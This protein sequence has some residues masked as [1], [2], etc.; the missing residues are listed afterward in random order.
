MKEKRTNN[1]NFQK[2]P[3]LRDKLSWTHYRLLLIALF[4]VTKDVLTKDVLT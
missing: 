1:I 2:S 4:I 3:A